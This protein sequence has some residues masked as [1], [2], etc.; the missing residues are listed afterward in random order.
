MSDID[1]ELNKLCCDLTYR[2]REWAQ[3]AWPEERAFIDVFKLSGGIG[4]CGLWGFWDDLYANQSR[5]IRPYRSVG[6]T[7][8]AELLSKSRRFKRSIRN[9]DWDN[10]EV[11][12]GAIR[13]A[14]FDKLEDHVFSE[15]YDIMPK[16][17]SWV[18]SNS[19]AAKRLSGF[20]KLVA[21]FYGVGNMMRKTIVSV[22]K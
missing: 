1:D 7:N 15:L 9:C 4:G 12:L 17:K 10:R 5:I 20:G 14:E 11:E 6:A 13:S 21:N 3:F 8:L 16:L 2:E 19:I 22:R 18:Y